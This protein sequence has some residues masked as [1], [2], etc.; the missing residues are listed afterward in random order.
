[1]S[2]DRLIDALRAFWWWLWTSHDSRESVR[3]EIEEQA[4]RFGGEVTWRD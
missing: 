3:R 1:M 2:L 4:R